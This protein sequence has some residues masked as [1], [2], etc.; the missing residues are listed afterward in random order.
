[1]GG[2][3]FKKTYPVIRLDKI[4]YNAKVITFTRILNSIGISRFH[5]VEAVREKVDFGD[6]DI[7]IEDTTDNKLKINNWLKDQVNIPV[8]QNGN[9]QSILHY[10]FQIDFIYVQPDSF[11]YACSYFN[12]NDFGNIVGRLSK[13]YGFKHGW[14]GL[15]YVQRDLKDNNRILHEHLLS[16]DYSDVLKILQLDVER[17]NQGFD[18]FEDMFNYIITSPLFLATPYSYENLNHQNR[19]RDKKRVTYN[20]FLKF[21]DEKFSST[22]KSLEKKLTEDE[23]LF[24]VLTNFPEIKKDLIWHQQ[25]ADEKRRYTAVFNGRVLKELLPSLDVREYSAFM[26]FFKKSNRPSSF[27]SLSEEERV[28]L[29]LKEKE[30]YDNEKN[31]PAAFS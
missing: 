18:T 8:V 20:N 5:I 19:V 31:A 1:M 25:E 15:Y 27:S 12:W 11:E 23:K 30:N 22:H 3:V 16:L 28:S 6:M 9:V 4:K 29:I 2:N 14:Q 24:H 10:L 7:V 17:F 26:S 13:Q 21:I